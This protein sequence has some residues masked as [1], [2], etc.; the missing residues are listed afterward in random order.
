M[1]T[2]LEK[3]KLARLLEDLGAGIEAIPTS[4]LYPLSDLAGKQL[5]EFRAVWDTLPVE[6]RRRLARALVDFAET[7]FEVNFDAI[8]TYSL[9]DHDHEIRA[10]AIDGLWENK[11]TAL[12][13]P[14]LTMLR[15]DPSPEVRSAAAAGLGRYVL[16]GE[17]EQLEQTI[18]SRIVSELLTTFHLIGESVDVRRRALESAAYACTDEVLELLDLAY[19]DDEEEMR[20]SAITGMG[21]SCDQRWAE[22]ILIELDSST[23]AMRYAAALASGELA[24]RQAAPILAQLIYDPDSQI[25]EA[26]IHAL[27]QMGGS[28]AKVALLAAYDESDEDTRFAIDEALAEH[29]LAEGDLDF[30]LYQVDGDLSADLGDKDD[31]DLWGD[32]GDEPDDTDLD[33]WML[34]A[35]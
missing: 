8:Y 32:G 19:Y 34:D 15:S 33:D 27:G 10:A 35:D 3:L 17:L 18:Q 22:N 20:I 29:A 21:R 5:D 16:A 1:P 6:R 2:D 30:L 7:N 28:E 11:E 9:V 13:G 31:Y 4:Q 25:R 12:V 26:A 24:L 14:F 23:D